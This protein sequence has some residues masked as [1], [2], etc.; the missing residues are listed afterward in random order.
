MS[1]TIELLSYGVGVLS[2]VGLPKL[3]R[4]KKEDDGSYPWLWSAK[5]HAFQCPKCG[6]IGTTKQP[7]YCTCPE[8]PTDHYHYVCT[9]DDKTDKSKATSPCGFR[10]IMHPRKS[11]LWK[12]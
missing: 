12:R 5:Y 1:I 10:C 6:S 8:Y 11:K 2:A 3:L 9:R 7:K 4:L